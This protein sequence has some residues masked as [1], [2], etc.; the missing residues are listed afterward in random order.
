MK[1]RRSSHLFGQKLGVTRTRALLL[2]VL[3]IFFFSS[4]TYTYFP[5]FGQAVV[6]GVVPS[7]PP[8]VLAFDFYRA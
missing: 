8:Q 3:K 4:Y 7:L 1:S 6:T 2:C 5:A